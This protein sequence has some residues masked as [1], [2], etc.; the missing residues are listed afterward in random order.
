[1]DFS[2]RNRY[3]KSGSSGESSPPPSCGPVS[4]VTMTTIGVADTPSKARVSVYW[5]F[6]FCTGCRG[7]LSSILCGPAEDGA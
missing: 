3:C 7:L 6:L 4:G 1:M 5:T 2:D